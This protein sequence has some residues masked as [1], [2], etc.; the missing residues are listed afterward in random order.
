MG[1]RGATGIAG[2]IVTGAVIGQTG[3]GHAILQRA[4]LA[5]EPAG[6]T[7][8]SFLHPLSLPES[9][10]SKRE[11]VNLSFTIANHT[12]SSNNYQW[13]LRI[14]ERGSSRELASGQMSLAPAQM[15]IIT[16]SVAIGCTAGQA[17]ITVAVAHP[18]QSI[19]VWAA[20][21]THKS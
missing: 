16:E 3:I 2:I 20:C 4:G 19:D 1:W 17:K 6:Y 12:A 5:A 13:S 10:S 11:N 7:S 15:K 8:L 14:R 9:L 21:G 18:A